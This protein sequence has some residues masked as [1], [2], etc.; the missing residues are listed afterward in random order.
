VAIRCASSSTRSRTSPNSSGCNS[1][2][3][4]HTRLAL[5]RQLVQSMHGTLDVSSVVG[6]GST[7]WFELAVADPVGVDGPTMPGG[8]ALAPYTYP[9][10]RRL[11]YV[12]DMVE[13]IRLVEQ[14]LR[15]R[16]AVT[17]IPA[18]LAGVALNLAR[19]HQ[20]DLILLDLHLP[21]MPGEQFLVN[22]RAD[23]LTRGAAPYL[24][25]NCR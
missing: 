9:T 16:P 22:L 24:P 17:L 7:F 12:E 5:S 19:D 11:L 18:M 14:I 15:Y 23:H 2:T 8:A 6:E 21:D 25:V 4:R 10:P 13:N 3:V 20:P 1:E